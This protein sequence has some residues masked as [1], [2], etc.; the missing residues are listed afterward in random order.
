MIHI[1]MGHF[2]YVSAK[3]GILNCPKWFR[4][5]IKRDSEGLSKSKLQK[6]HVTEEHEGYI[7][8]SF[9]FSKSFNYL[10]YVNISRGNPKPHLLVCPFQ[11]K[12]CKDSFCSSVRIECRSSSVKLVSDQTAIISPNGSIN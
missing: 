11:K 1:C 10:H 5:L 6:S 7:K 8:G 2:F 4:H 12:S 9:I 3:E